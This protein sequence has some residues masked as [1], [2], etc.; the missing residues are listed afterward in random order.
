[1]NPENFLKEITKLVPKKFDSSLVLTISSV[2]L[3]GVFMTLLKSSNVPEFFTSPIFKISAVVI[4][5]IFLQKDAM[6][7]VLLGLVTFSCIVFGEINKVDSL[8]ESFEDNEEEEE[9]E[10]QEE[11]DEQE[12]QEEQESKN[13]SRISEEEF[14]ENASISKNKYVNILKNQ[15]DGVVDR[16]MELNDEDGDNKI[17][18]TE[19]NSIFP[20]HENKS[21]EQLDTL[22]K[23]ADKNGNGKLNKRDLVDY[24]VDRKMNRLDNNADSRL[25]Y[26]EM[27]PSE[28][29]EVEPEVEGFTGF[30]NSAF[31]KFI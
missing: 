7:G 25:S 3:V 13:R 28:M 11:Q 17:N 4:T 26:S 18:R 5:A 27:T 24:I 21:E 22:F 31:S 6:L 20:N 10:E 15:E 29:E 1:M 23:E 19:F 8:V 9:E 16:K 12:E 2:L 30:G 14:L